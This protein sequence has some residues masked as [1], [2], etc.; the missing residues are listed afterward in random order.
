MFLPLHSTGSFAAL[1]SKFSFITASEHKF[2]SFD[3]SPF[4]SSTTAITD[5]GIKKVSIKS[6]F[7]MYCFLCVNDLIAIKIW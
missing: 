7:S 4:S 5:V 3:A 1:N 2:A 6:F